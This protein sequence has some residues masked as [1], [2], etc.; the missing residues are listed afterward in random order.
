MRVVKRP[1][2]NR[3]ANDHVSLSTPTE[4]RD[5]AIASALAR[6]R[7]TRACVRACVRAC[8]SSRKGRF[9]VLFR[10]IRLTSRRLM[11][12]QVLWFTRRHIFK[13][14]PRPWYG[15]SELSLRPRVSD[16]VRKTTRL[17]ARSCRFPEVVLFNTPSKFHAVAFPVLYE[18][19]KFC[20]LFY[21]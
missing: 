9:Y 20:F 8:I 14:S 3:I 11:V 13:A 12:K 6:V 18:F 15:C 5:L 16:R 19:D 4:A 2:K 1:A 10:R 21:F 7:A 17:T